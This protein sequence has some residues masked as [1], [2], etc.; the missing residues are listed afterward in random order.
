MELNALLARSV[1]PFIDSTRGETA[2]EDNQVFL[3]NLL[4]LGITITDQK[5]YNQGG[6]NLK[7][8][9]DDMKIKFRQKK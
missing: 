7:N 8:R 5:G 3:N 4:G 2:R 6:S 9:L 1:K